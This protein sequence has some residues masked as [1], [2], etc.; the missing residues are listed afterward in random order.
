MVYQSTDVATSPS[1]TRKTAPPSGTAHE[2]KDSSH[3][4]SL[5]AEIGIGVAVPLVVIGAVVAGF[6]AWQRR[7]KSKNT[8]AS[9]SPVERGDHHKQAEPKTEELG[10]VPV[11]EHAGRE[12]PAELNARGRS[13]RQ[14]EVAELSADP[15]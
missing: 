8:Q 14:A 2:S 10:G 4:L 15:S 12:R 5:G 11:N 6:Y 3:G 7:I 13:K 1:S 9:G